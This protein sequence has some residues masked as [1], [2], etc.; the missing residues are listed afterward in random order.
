MSE[1]LTEEMSASEYLEWINPDGRH[2]SRNANGTWYCHDCR[3]VVILS[4]DDQHICDGVPWWF[5]N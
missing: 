4:D 5:D 3:R 2:M 1:L